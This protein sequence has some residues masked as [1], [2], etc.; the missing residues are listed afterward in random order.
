MG[1]R[2]RDHG[3]QAAA[4]RAVTEIGLWCT[5]P[6][7]EVDC[8]GQDSNMA[9]TALQCVLNAQTDT[10]LLFC[11]VSVVYPKGVIPLCY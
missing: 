2:T 10:A 4:D 7:S 1:I 3:S 11:V 8:A 9:G 6:V 5:L